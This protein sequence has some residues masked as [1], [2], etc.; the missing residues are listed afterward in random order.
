MRRS[1]RKLAVFVIALLGSALLA[2]CGGESGD[3]TTSTEMSLPGAPAPALTP[4]L[5]EQAPAQYEDSGEQ[6][7]DRKEVVTGNVDIT[8]DDPIVAAGSVADRVRELDGRIDRRTEQPGTDDDLPR[9][10]LTVRIPADRTDAFIDGLGSIGRVT[11]V[12]TNRDD[13]TMQWADLDARIAALRASVDRLRALLAAADN[14]ADLIA[15]EE[16]LA[17][18]Q[19]EL[20]SLTAQKRRLDDQIALSTLTITITADA[21]TKP[22][23]EPANFWDGLVFGWNSL[24]D[25]LKD[26]VVFAGKAVP[27][28]G[29]LAVLGVIAWAITGLAQRISKGRGGTSVNDPGDAVR[30]SSATGGS[31]HTAASDDAASSTHTAAPEAAGS[32]RA[33]GA[34]GATHSGKAERTEDPLQD[35][36]GSGTVQTPT[37]ERDI[38]TTSPGNAGAADAEREPD[39]GRGIGFDDAGTP[40]TETQKEPGAS[41]DHRAGDDK[42]EQ[43]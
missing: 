24:V 30:Q 11:E 37:G 19:G 7:T 34:A 9:A 26:A 17:S 25:W 35:A 22:D 31:A 12:G 14:T 8:A 18:R 23:N 10:E 15:A 16:A 43:P 4:G 3:G 41:G 1:T 5:R 2:G 13:V 21:D 39:S 40:D 38:P 28:I 6:A 32:D 29:F 42:T 36:A 33:A 27:W 20:D